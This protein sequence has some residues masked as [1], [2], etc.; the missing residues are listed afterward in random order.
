MNSAR[1]TGLSAI[2]CIFLSGCVKTP[3]SDGMVDVSVNEIVRRLKCELVEA[4]GQKSQEDARFGFLSQW[5]AKVH[6][7][8]V[9]D[10]QVSINPGATLIE[11]LKIAGTSRSLAVG[12]GLTTQAVRP[13]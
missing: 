12:A 9:V 3:I 8:L 13:E 1:F 2:A 6:L 4:V 5:A 7:T 10:D 11:P